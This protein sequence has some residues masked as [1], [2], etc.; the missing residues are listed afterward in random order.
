MRYVDTNHFKMYLKLRSKDPHHAG[1][2]N[3]LL[4]PEAG[5]VGEAGFPV[6]E[7]GSAG[8]PDGFRGLEPTV[9]RLFPVVA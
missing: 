8:F 7:F 1:L 9:P 2:F 6:G 4:I 5:P 3:Y